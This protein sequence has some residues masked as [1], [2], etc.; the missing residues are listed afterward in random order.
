MRSRTS[1][2]QDSVPPNSAPVPQMNLSSPLP[3]PPMSAAPFRMRE[4]SDSVKD[5]DVLGLEGARE[6]GGYH[7]RPPRSVKAS[8]AP[9]TPAVPPP[10]SANRPGSTLGQRTPVA[11]AQHEGMI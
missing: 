6:G 10:R 1:A 9:R 8:P 7:E 4:R 5:R 3:R 11:I 2:Q